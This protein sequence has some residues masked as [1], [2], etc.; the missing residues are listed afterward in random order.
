MGIHFIDHPNTFKTGCRVVSL[1]NRGRGTGQ[2]STKS[3]VTHDENEFDTALKLLLPMM[4]DVDDR[5]Y[6]SLSERDINKAI[7]TFKERQLQAD[8][9]QHTENF[10]RNVKARWISCLMKPSNVKS[11]KKLWLLDCDSPEDVE[12]AKRVLDESYDRD[13]KPYEYD[14]R[15]EGR[16][17]IIIKPFNSKEIKVK[18]GGGHDLMLWAWIV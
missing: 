13:F 18:F 6:S 15:G 9:D 5:I 17:H 8:Y 14:S 10:Y 2:K 16:K 11:G 7:R 3:I 4:V 1:I 12:L